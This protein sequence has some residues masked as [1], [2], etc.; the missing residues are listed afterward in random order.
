MNKRLDPSVST[1]TQGCAIL[2]REI[3]CKSILTKSGISSIDYAINPYVGCEHACVYCYA[4]FMKRF[5][6]HT[7]EWGTFVDVKV[8]AP[9][10]LAREIQRAKPGNV[11]FGTVTDAYQP[12]EAKYRITRECLEVLQD[13]DMPVSILTKSSLVL[14][15]LDLIKTLRRPEVAFTIATVNEEVR[16]L[17]EP[18]SS[19]I[20]QRL[21]ALRTLAEAGI[22][23]WAFC[24]PVLP[25]ISDGEPALRA[26]FAEL[27]KARVGYV[28]V[29]SLNLRG[30]AWGRVMRVLKAHYPE[31]VDQYRALRSNRKPYHAAL[32]E[33]TRRIA[34]EYDLEWEGVNL[35]GPAE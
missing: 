15:D 6:G 21:D 18:C 35:D 5:T 34:A 25:F 10:V 1:T 8:N 32:M 20:Q 12:L 2:V 24:G 9:Q 27:A 31:L 16:R 4:T 3:E 23:T 30:A 11:S 22:P 7:E 28:L 29:D 14:R 13:W 33:R 19:P 17:F 26:L